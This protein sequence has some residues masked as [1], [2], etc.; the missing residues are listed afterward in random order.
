MT[1]ASFTAAPLRA[2][3]PA[4]PQPGAQGDPESADP[5]PSADGPLGPVR[6]IT[7]VRACGPGRTELDVSSYDGRHVRLTK[8][9]IPAVPH[10]K[11]MTGVIP[12][13]CRPLAVRFEFHDDQSICTCVATTP[14]GPKRLD[15]S[16]SAGLALVASGVH[17]IVT[18]APAKGEL[19]VAEEG[20]VPWLSA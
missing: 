3:A 19:A 13:R 17:G 1:T 2:K 5:R 15:V 4:A 9:L 20:D 11:V 16:N 12:D 18:L 6:V 10:P 8:V 14:T 7:H